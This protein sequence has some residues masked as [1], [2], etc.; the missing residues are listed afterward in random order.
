MKKH[1]K[2]WGYYKILFESDTCKVKQILVK[3]GE[4]LSYQYHHKR[5]EVWTIVQGEAYVL[6]D[7]ELS[8][9]TYGE[10]IFIPQGT[11]HQVENKGQKDLVFIEVQHG[12]YFGEDDIVRIKDKY[13]R[14]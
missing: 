13:N 6:L 4:I 1:K 3:P 11:K 9:H 8:L 10:T 7:D 2:P 5:S 12:S 14:K